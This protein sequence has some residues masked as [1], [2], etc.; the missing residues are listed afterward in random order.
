MPVVLLA[1]GEACAGRPNTPFG[2][3]AAGARELKG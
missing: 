3:V 2:P 1:S